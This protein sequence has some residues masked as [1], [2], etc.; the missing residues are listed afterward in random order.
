MKIKLATKLKLL[1]IEIM[2][3]SGK[4]SSELN[5]WI[6]LNLQYIKTKLSNIETLNYIVKVMEKQGVQE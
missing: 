5:F 4:N 6:V 2:T 3:F 1:K